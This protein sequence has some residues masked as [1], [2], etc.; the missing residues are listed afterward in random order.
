[1]R[2]ASVVWADVLQNVVAKR[3]GSASSAIGKTE[4]RSGARGLEWGRFIDRAIAG[5][6]AGRVRRESH[7]KP[8]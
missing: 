8:L 4:G 3:L 6:A 5:G 2:L 1:M 7:D